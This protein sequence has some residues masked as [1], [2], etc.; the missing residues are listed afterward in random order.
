MLLA[1]RNISIY[2]ERKAAVCVSKWEHFI[3]NIFIYGCNKLFSWMF[4][5]GS[6]R[7]T[8][9][10]KDWTSYLFS[11]SKQNSWLMNTIFL[12]RRAHI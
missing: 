3:K 2:K 1:S 9:C 5:F 4:V 6:L 7:S 8:V 11:T 10:I 12:L